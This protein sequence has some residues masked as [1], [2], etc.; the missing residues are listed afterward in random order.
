MT[1]FCYIFNRQS[2][3]AVSNT[4]K[5]LAL[6]MENGEYDFDGTQEKPVSSDYN[7]FSFIDIV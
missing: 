6:A 4:T 7:I 5:K 2:A 1:Y 3:G